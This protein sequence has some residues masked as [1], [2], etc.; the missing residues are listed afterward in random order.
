MHEGFNYVGIELQ[1]DYFDLSQ[2]RLGSM[3]ENLSV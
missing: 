2:I 1:K 3:P